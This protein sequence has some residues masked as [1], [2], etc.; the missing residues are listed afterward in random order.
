MKNSVFRGIPKIHFRKHPTSAVSKNSF[1][2]FGFIDTILRWKL[3]PQKHFRGLGN[4]AETPPPPP[5]SPT[6][7]VRVH[8]RGNIQGV[9]T[10]RYFYRMWVRGALF[11][12]SPRSVGKRG[13]TN[14]V[15]ATAF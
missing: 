8:H 15:L 9:T 10:G 4:N 7:V 14:T 13:N 5:H 1:K 12:I 6:V 11:L 2:K 3:K